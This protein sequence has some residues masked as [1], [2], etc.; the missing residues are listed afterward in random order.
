MV[1]YDARRGN[2][3]TK[4]YGFYLQEQRLL[5]AA[6]K[7]LAQSFLVWH[8]DKEFDAVN[9]CVKY[10]GGRNQQR[11][12]KTLVVACR[13]W[14]EL[15]DGYWGQFSITILLHGEA[16]HLLPNQYQHL[17]SMQNFVGMIEYSCIG[18]R[19]S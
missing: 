3:S 9:S 10:R 1:A 2:F 12:S 11:H 4:M 6:Q 5:A 16:A 7:P 18:H 15:T 17:Q 13:Y 19:H 8:R 14:F